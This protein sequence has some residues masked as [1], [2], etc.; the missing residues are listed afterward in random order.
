LLIAV[1]AWV[2]AQI[3]KVTLVLV[4]EKRL[5]WNFFFSSGGMPSAHAATVCALTT[6]VAMTLGMGS[7]YFS[8][9]VVLAI[10][11]I[12]DAAGVRQSVGQHSVVLNRLVREF[13]FKKPRPAFE[14]D[15]KEFIGHTPI[16]VFMGAVQG[17]LIAW[18]WVTISR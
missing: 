10:I 11:V 18:L 17:I 14:K 5:A 12:Y 8:I 15:F 7:P 16:Q 9:A 1:C 2:I 3:T 4:Q 13:S 6:A